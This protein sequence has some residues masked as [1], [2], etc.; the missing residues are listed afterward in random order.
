MAEVHFATDPVHSGSLLS[1]SLLLQMYN[2]SLNNPN[3]PFKLVYTLLSFVKQACLWGIGSRVTP[4]LSYLLSFISSPKQT[5]EPPPAAP[6]G[7]KL[8]LPVAF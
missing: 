7:G 3:Y 4:F 1:S 6:H 2:P 5:D 8:V